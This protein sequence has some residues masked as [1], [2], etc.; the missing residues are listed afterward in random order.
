MKPIKSILR[1]VRH[2][3]QR[4]LQAD[5][6]EREARLLADLARLE[7]STTER[8]EGRIAQLEASLQERLGQ[9]TTEIQQRQTTAE[10][11]IG[12]LDTRLEDRL[13]AVD[14]R[15]EERLGAVDHRLEERL[16][17][18]DTRVEAH[19]VGLD[20]RFDEQVVTVD[21]RFDERLETIEE[22][23]DQRLADV[24]QQ[25][26]YLDA[27]LE[28][29]LGAVD[30]RLE[31]RL[32]GLDLQANERFAAIDRQVDERFTTIEGRFDSRFEA[33]EQQVNQRF[34]TIETRVDGRL[35]AMVQQI[36]ERTATIAAT[37]DRRATEYEQSVDQ[38]LEERF[39]KME[40]VFK[41]L[42]SDYLR[43]VDIRIDDRQ[44]GVDRRI[45]DRFRGL[46]QRLDER[47]EA[48]E[49]RTDQTLELNREGIL[50]RT[51]LL[52][53]VFEQRLDQ[54]RQALAGG[55]PENGPAAR[56][57]DAGRE[58]ERRLF[59]DEEVRSFGKLVDEGALDTAGSRTG[60]ARLGEPLYREI[61]AWEKISREGLGH[62]PPEEQE[63]VEYLLSFLEN[64]DDAN[65]YV[66][67]HLRRLVGTIQRIPPPP[68]TTA[69]L[70]ELGSLF[71][72]APAIRRFCGYQTIVGTS[73]WEGEE[74]QT[75][76]TYRQ[77]R[78][79]SD[80]L[81]IPLH[82]FNVEQD[83]FPFADQTFRV[84]LCCE[85]IEHLP[86]DPMHMLWE[87]NRV[88]E[89]EGYLLLTTPNITSSR[90]LE[91]ILT[92]YSPYHFS[93]YNL[94]PPYDRHHREY[95]PAEVEVA[96]RAAGF[97]VLQL[98]TEDVWRRS[99]PAILRLLEEVRL[100]TDL[101]G[102]NIFA[103]AQKSGPPLE[104]YPKALY[105]P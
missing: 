41:S 87:C 94:E 53:Q 63:I 36:E 56:G 54:F 35:D 83:R 71:S 27:R 105:V 95:A 52:L 10:E 74:K 12:R 55:L 81:T 50:D 30:T 65:G 82:N 24:D 11:W 28:E 103:L 9:L 14:L 16:G 43:G 69:Q 21:T 33:I 44:A 73:W 80:E 23:I 77:L 17:T 49:L 60:V 26:A 4:D 18:I 45:E 59:L 6:I 90:A 66:Q 38:R 31:E 101:R 7:Q 48:H 91:G 72:L 37:Q 20:T 22:R 102:D 104:R 39:A 40:Q 29:R 70:L 8:E 2:L 47:L 67:Q 84:V 5:A 42:I 97:Q 13:G 57:N 58:G 96:L 46:D 78:G 86:R 85:L 19:L 89:E 88:L 62:F 76:R 99:N 75:E 92:G 68:R 79:G 1:N 15:L 51:D 32:G 25:I 3:L 64:P 93:Q 34:E 100:S 61:E 98:E